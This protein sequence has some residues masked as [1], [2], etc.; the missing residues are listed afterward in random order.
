MSEKKK[1]KIKKM[2]LLAP[3]LELKQK[4]FQRTRAPLAGQWRNQKDERMVRKATV[5][6]T[7]R[8]REPVQAN[9]KL[10]TDSN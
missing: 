5:Q 1:N 8:K 9:S 2:K 10:R 3:N 7:A 4:V 6:L